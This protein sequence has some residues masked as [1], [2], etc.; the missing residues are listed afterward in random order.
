MKERLKDELNLN[1]ITVFGKSPEMFILSLSIRHT[2]HLGSNNE[3]VHIRIFRE[4]SPTWCKNVCFRVLYGT[5]TINDL[6][7]R[8]FFSVVVNTK[9]CRKIR[10]VT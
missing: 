5:L 9:R 2:E 6:L 8:D 4:V 10:L 7:K 1:R 3:F